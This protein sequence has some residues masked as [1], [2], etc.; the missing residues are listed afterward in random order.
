MRRR[1][2]LPAGFLTFSDYSVYLDG[3]GTQ[4]G[5]PPSLVLW[6]CSRSLGGPSGAGFDDGDAGEGA[7]AGREALFERLV[8]AVPDLVDDPP[9]AGRAGHVDHE[10]LGGARGAADLDVVDLPGAIALS[11]QLALVRPPEI[12]VA[13]GVEQ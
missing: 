13:L 2:P 5:C 3:V 10:V 1:A 7:E 6:G 11:D 9:V 12:V 4:E 8:R